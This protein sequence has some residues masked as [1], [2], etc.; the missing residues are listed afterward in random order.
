VS[1]GELDERRRVDDKERARLFGE[2]FRLGTLQRVSR[3]R[4]LTKPT[5]WGIMLGVIVFIVGLPVLGGVDA[6]PNPLAA[7]V[8][9]TAMVGALFAACCWLLVAGPAR[10]PVTSR[11]F[12][13]SGGL[14]QLVRDEPEPRVA[15]WADVRDITV[16]YFDAEDA[17]AR[18]NGFQVTTVTGTVLPGLSGY[19]SRRK[20]RPLVA[21]AERALAP[22]LVPAMTAAYES[23]DTVAFG[24]VLVGEAGITLSAWA[25]PGELTPWSQVKSIHMLYIFKADGD[26][27][28]EVTVGLRGLP[29][30]QIRISGLANGIFLPHLLAYAAARQ[31]V[32]VTGY[33]KD[34]GGIPQ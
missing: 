29:T 5:A 25:S 6:G 34:G 27:V 2:E 12:R 7:R 11:L 9:V 1:T 15:R 16:D 19:W 23:G 20:L 3:G 28:D 32:M 30:E 10:S 26:Y 18:L 21:A 33:H 31:G 17:A 8:A 14:A 13:Y 24:R 22:R 4:G